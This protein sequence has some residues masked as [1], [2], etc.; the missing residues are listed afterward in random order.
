MRVVLIQV[1]FVAIIFC[2]TG[3]SL[4]FVCV[5]CDAFDM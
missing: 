2:A 1:Y 4:V 3:N 5:S